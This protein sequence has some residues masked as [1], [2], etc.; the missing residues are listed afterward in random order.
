MRPWTLV[1]GRKPHGHDQKGE[2]AGLQQPGRVSTS[3]ASA[4]PPPATTYQTTQ[5]MLA[6]TAPSLT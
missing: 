5:T 6:M 1:V 4:P 3:E 2:K